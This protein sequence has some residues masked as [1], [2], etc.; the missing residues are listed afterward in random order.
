MASRPPAPGRAA[1]AL[2]ACALLA[3]T[4]LVAPGA[5]AAPAPGQAAMQTVYAVGDIARCRHPD[6]RWSGAADTAAVVAAGLAADPAAVV[7]TL[8]DHTYPRGTAAEFT[9]CYGPTWAASRTAPGRRRATTSTTRRMQ[10][11]T[12]PISAR[13]PD[14]A[15]TAC[16]WAPGA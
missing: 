11:P 16:S 8:G 2:A 9:W 15:T 1:R 14:A 6:P 13:A 5:T 12:S 7:L 3:G 10:R 4:P